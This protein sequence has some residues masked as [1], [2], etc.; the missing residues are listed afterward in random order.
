MQIT[1]NIPDA[2]IVTIVD[3]DTVLTPLGEN[4]SNL[5]QEL[6]QVLSQIQVAEALV[7]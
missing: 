6:F 7:N 5:Y 4:S 3:G 2:H 1:D